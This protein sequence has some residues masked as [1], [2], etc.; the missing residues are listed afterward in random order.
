LLT[1]YLGLLQ[2]SLVLSALYLAYMLKE[3]YSSNRQR[4]SSLVKD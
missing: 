3:A 2:T 4:T 1:Q